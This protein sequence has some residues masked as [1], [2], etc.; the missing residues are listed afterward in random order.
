MEKMN[1][2]RKLLGR[3]FHLSTEYGG[4]NCELMQWKLFKN[5]ENGDPIYWSDDNKAIMSSGTHTIDD[6]YKFAKS[7][8]KYDVERFILRMNTIILLIMVLVSFA[9]IF[10]NSV[11]IRT[12]V[13]TCDAILMLWLGAVTYVSN[14]NWK[15]DKLEMQENWKRRREELFKK[16]EG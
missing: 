1:K 3:R 5:Y 13:L 10:I 4:E 11:I 6:L 16:L 12:I 8:K 9:N 7:H 14:K 2:I 15:V